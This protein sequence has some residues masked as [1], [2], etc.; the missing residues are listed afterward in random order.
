VEKFCIRAIVVVKVKRNVKLLLSFKV[1]ASRMSSS[2]VV[3]LETLTPSQEYRD[4]KWARVLRRRNIPVST[5]EDLIACLDC[6][7]E[8][9]TTLIF[10]EQM[11]LLQEQVRKNLESLGNKRQEAL[12]TLTTVQ[13]VQKNVDDPGEGKESSVVGAQL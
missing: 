13:V 10:L 7:T 3:C 8:M 11:D 1:A 12:K 2:C 9:S 6:G 5:G 4:K